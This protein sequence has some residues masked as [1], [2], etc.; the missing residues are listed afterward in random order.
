MLK[1][2]LGCP[3]FNFLKKVIE[4]TKDEYPNFRG[5]DY[6]LERKKILET[7]TGDNERGLANKLFYPRLIKGDKQEE[8]TIRKNFAFFNFDDYVDNVSQAD[9]Y[10]TISNIVN[11][12]RNS[13][14]NTDKL[15]RTLKQSVYVYSYEAD[16]PNGVYVDPLN[17]AM[18]TPL[19]IDN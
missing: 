11:S 19:I 6:L 12:V 14:G 1:I 3:K 7:S 4:F 13:N 2:H 18:L 10:F 9:I 17:G 15:D 5:I 8:L 16:P